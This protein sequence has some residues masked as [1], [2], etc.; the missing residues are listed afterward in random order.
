MNCR[1]FETDVIDLARGVDLDE[2]TRRRLDRHL[3]TCEACASR[4]AREQTLSAALREVAGAVAGSPGADAIEQELLRALA[5]ERRPVGGTVA[6]ST[7]ART[8]ALGALRSVFA[9]PGSRPWLAAA[10]V[11]VVAVVAW[12]GV[13]RWRGAPETAPPA[14]DESLAFVALPNAAGLPPLE[15]GRVV[16][17]AVPVAILPAYGFRVDPIQPSGFVEADVLVGQDDQPRAIR[18]VTS[19]SD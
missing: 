2:E 11:L 19:G 3:Q 16:R 4:V 17:V 15:S 8:S 5:R 14:S 18:F 1:G 13:T 12:Q 10:A 9:A 6:P 7:N